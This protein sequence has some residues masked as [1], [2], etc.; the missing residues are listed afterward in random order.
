MRR[1]LSILVLSALPIAA[2]ANLPE[3]LNGY[4]NTYISCI[5]TVVG[6]ALSEGN[7]V[8]ESLLLSA[9]LGELASLKAVIPKNMEAMF[10]EQLKQE[11]KANVYKQV[12]LSD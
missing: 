7:E 1:S 8:T 11:V 9:C 4:K 3:P 6:Q 12:T 10:S 5:N 2:S